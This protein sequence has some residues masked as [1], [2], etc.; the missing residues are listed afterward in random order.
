MKSCEEIQR[1]LSEYMDGELS[2]ELESQ[3]QQHLEQCSGCREMANDLIALKEAATDLAHPPAGV[4]AP[5]AAKG[6]AELSAKLGED[7][8]PGPQQRTWPY[9]AAAALAAALLVALGV[10]VLNPGD[11]M[12]LARQQAR[13]ELSRLNEQQQRAIRSLKVLVE[14]RKDT[15]NHKLHKVFARNAELVD[16]AIEECRLAVDQHPADRELLASLVEAYQRKVDFLKIFSGL[17][18]KP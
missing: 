15:W 13:A 8:I 12:E 1:S 2:P 9:L 16:A 17:E 6:W 11:D 4:E 5:D 7:P 14:K 3:V 18:E 10:T